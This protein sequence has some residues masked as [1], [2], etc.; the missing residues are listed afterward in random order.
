MST[1]TP[2]P[3]ASE[4]SVTPFTISRIFEA[5]CELVWKA[6]TEVES[7]KQWWAPEG[8]SVS[9]CRLDLRPGGLLHY[10]LSSA[11][12]FEMWGKSVYGEIVPQEKLVFINSFSDKDAGLSRHPMSATWPLE[13]HT[14]IKFTE[15]KGKTMLNI[16]WLPISPTEE[17]C[18]TFDNAREGMSLGWTGTLDYLAAYLAKAQADREIISTRVIDAPRERV[19][20]AWTDPE[21]L[22]LWWGPKGFTNTFHEFDLKPGGHWRFIMHGPDGTDYP[23]HSVFVEI[24]KPDRLILDHLSSPHF[25][26]VATFSEEEGKTKNTFRMIFPSAEMCEK[27]KPICVPANEE[28]FDRLTALLAKA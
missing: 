26:V 15:H 23:N 13:M 11:E 14:R 8:F 10:C 4:T 20:Q 7:L 22:A 21:Q 27:L 25:R 28:N 17:E 24:V 3:A 12:G 2:I 1:T 19:F 9:V 6:W 16:Q 18:V 5:P